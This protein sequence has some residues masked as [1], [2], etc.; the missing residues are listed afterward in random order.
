M[1]AKRWQM[2]E[3]K[4]RLS[5]VI[6]KACKEGPQEISIRGKVTAIML[7]KEQ[8]KHLTSPKS[9]FIK[10]LQESPLFGSKLEIERDKSL[11]REV[12]L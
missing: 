12:E 2:Q 11:C 7:S 4:A 10:F 1:K 6:Q 3:A 5:E 8:Y 9:S